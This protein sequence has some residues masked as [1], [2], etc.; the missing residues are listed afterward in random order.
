[1][2]INGYIWMIRINV[3]DKHKCYRTMNEEIL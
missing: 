3:M 2:D 1:M